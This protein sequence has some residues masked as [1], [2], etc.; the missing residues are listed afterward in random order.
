MEVKKNT[1]DPSKILQVG[2]GFWASK[3]LLTAVGLELFTILGNTELTGNDI[4][5]QLNLHDRSLYD[6]LDALVAMG[7]LERH[8]GIREQGR[9][10]NT[11]ETA[12]FLDKASPAYLGGILEMCNTRL[13]KFWDNLEDGLKTGKAQNEIKTGDESHFANIYATEESTRE[14]MNAMAGIQMGN[15]IALAKTFDFSNYQT[16]CDIGGA[17]ANL[18]MEIVKSHPH[19]RSASFDLP[20]VNAIAASNIKKA[21]LTDAVELISGDFFADDLPNADIITMGNI[22]HD[23]NLEEKKVL[24]SKA[25][26]ALS[27]KGVLVVIENIIDDDRNENAFGLLMSLCM[28]IETPGGFDYS[29]RDFDAWAKETGFKRTEKL[30]LT[31]PSSA[32]IA[33]KS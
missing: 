2:M 28:L 19:I 17:G 5:E 20:N 29:A 25:F 22:L 8:G 15:F 7:F 26:K 23:W 3:T 33:Y 10:R 13:Y 24:I 18:S 11:P 6:F 9:Y 12:R 21:G 16:H 14:F 4:K 31:G 1:S 30:T 27:D 32:V